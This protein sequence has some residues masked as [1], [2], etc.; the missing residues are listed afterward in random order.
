MLR[1]RRSSKR[2]ALRTM[3]EHPHPTTFPVGV[4]IW[5]DSFHS[6]LG[7]TFRALPGEA[8]FL[9]SGRFRTGRTRNSRR[10]TRVIAKD[11]ATATP[12]ETGSSL[13][14]RGVARIGL[15]TWPIGGRAYGEVDEATAIDTMVAALDA[16]VRLFDV[17]DIYGEGRSE[18]L[19]GQATAGRD[20]VVVIG[21][22]GYLDEAG[23]RQDFRP[24]YLRDA[25]SASLERM[26]RSQIDTLLLHSP[27]QDIL[28]SSK[29]RAGMEALVEKGLVKRVGVSLRH[30]ET[31]PQ[32]R[33]RGAVAP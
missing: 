25:L 29:V 3:A 5:A 21:K 17:A 1:D 33:C 7:Q 10:G 6:G 27:P 26:G 8:P 13:T 19:L 20:D 28:D 32:Q 22:A 15:G 23:A 16:G 30:I 9:G 12:A 11:A 14:E 4:L 2:H 24:S 31:R 18:L